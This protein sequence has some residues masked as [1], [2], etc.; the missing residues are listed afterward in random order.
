MDDDPLRKLVTLA[1]WFDRLGGLTPVHE[2]LHRSPLPFTSAHFDRLHAGGIRVVYSMEEAVPA[3]LVRERFDWR[4]HFWTDD[5]PPTMPQ[6]QRFLDDYLALPPDVPAV[7]HCKAGWGRTGTAITCALMTKHG[8]SAQRALT[9][10]WGRVPAARDIM[11]W[12]G[13]ADFVRGYGASLKGRGL[14]SLPE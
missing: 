9:H 13:Q 7:V 6:L 8:W 14:D 10:Y 4:P 5:Q 1:D 11:E 12:N 3:S 2:N